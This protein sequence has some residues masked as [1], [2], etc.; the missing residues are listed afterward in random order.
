MKAIL[1]FNLPEDRNEH[2]IAIHAMDFALTCW[3]L[4]QQLRNWLKYGN[5]FNTAD[6]ALEATRETLNEILNQH[7]VNLNMIE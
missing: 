7:N 5:K 1:E 3:D 2:E 4:D 6:E